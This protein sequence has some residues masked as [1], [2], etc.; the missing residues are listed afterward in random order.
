MARIRFRRSR[1]AALICA[2][3]ASSE[4]ASYAMPVAEEQKIGEEVAA[5]A[6]RRLP[7]INDYEID[8]FISNMG[9]RIVKTLG[10]QP[11]KY[12]FFV[13][14]DDSMNAFAIPGGKVFVHAGLISRA[15]NEDEIA[16]VMAHEIAHAN[17]HHSVRQQQKGQV[18]NYA[19]LLGV[20]LSAINPVV[21]SAAMTAGMSQQLKYQRDFEREADFLGIDFAKKAGYEP[22]AMMGMLRKINAQQQLNPTVVPPYFQSHPLTGERMSYLE[23]A[24]GKSEWQV[25]TKAPTE[26]LLRVQA[27]ARAN[28]QTRKEAVPDYERALAAATPQQRPEALE[29]IGVLMAAGEDYTPAIGYLEEAEKAGRNVD[30]ELGRSYLRKGRL[31]DA[32]P[33]LM[34]AAAAAPKDWNALADLGDLHYQLGEY[35]PSVDA[36][37]KAVTAYPW[38]PDVE[39]SL[40]R[41]L[42]KAG[43]VGEAF[44]WYGRASELQ[45]QPAQALSYYQQAEKSLPPVD[46]LKGDLDGRIEK[47]EKATSGPPR[48]PVIRPE[49]G[50]PRLVVP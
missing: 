24:L 31:E 11:F 2:I 48:P 47:L 18:A 34:R 30:R 9:Q 3:V 41:A 43:K 1:T 42:N 19:T 45:G 28:A 25:K 27:I 15:S 37:R 21:G 22:A 35:Q 29:L 46:P 33:R 17:A 36:Y 50:G 49:R 40:G 6:R 38:L 20:L 32:R 14:R 44:Y 4:I 12:E 26:E 39:Q 5:E 10:T 16:G 7:L 23:S 13:V 8:A